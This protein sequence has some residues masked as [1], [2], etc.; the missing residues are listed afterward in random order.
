[1]DV[2]PSTLGLIDSDC[3]ATPELAIIR[4]NYDWKDTDIVTQQGWF[5]SGSALALPPSDV[6]TQG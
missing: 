5:G 6:S 3:L 4:I 1:M 2:V